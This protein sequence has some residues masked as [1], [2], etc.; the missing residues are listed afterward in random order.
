[1]N[2]G[3]ALLHKPLV[4]LMLPR[5]AQPNL[6]LDRELVSP[7]HA[8]GHALSVVHA[9]HQRLAALL[10]LVEHGAHLRLRSTVTSSQ[11]MTRPP[12]NW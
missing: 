9:D 11:P 1:V 3:V 2:G 5:H 7:V 12:R 4:V 10:T 6:R 8:P